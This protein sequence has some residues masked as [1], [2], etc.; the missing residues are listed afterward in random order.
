MI[1]KRWKCFKFVKYKVGKVWN[2]YAG[3]FSVV[4][5]MS[6]IFIGVYVVT[7]YSNRILSYPTGEDINFFTQIPALLLLGII[8]VGSL[9]IILMPHCRERI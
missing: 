5:V 2:K 9:T 8:I 1:D 4:F 6:L 7:C 3:F